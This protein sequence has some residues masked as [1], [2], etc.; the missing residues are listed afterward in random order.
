M[1]MARTLQN[2]YKS[3]VSVGVVLVRQSQNG[4]QVILFQ[5]DTSQKLTEISQAMFSESSS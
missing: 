4:K 1:K 5:C 2:G 3:H